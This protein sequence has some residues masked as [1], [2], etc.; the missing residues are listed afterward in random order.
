VEKLFPNQP[1]KKETPKPYVAD[2]IE[3]ETPVTILDSQRYIPTPIVPI[4]AK[5][6]AVIKSNNGKSALPFELIKK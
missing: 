4:P 3:L 6:K 2:P 5:G 1:F